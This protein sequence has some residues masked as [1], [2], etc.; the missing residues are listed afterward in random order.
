MRRQTGAPTPRRRTA[1][2]GPSASRNL[3]RSIPVGR[4]SALRLGDRAHCRSCACLVLPRLDDARH[5]RDHGL[6]GDLRQ[7]AKMAPP[8]AANLPALR[9]RPLLLTGDD[10]QRMWIRR[11]ARVATAPLPTAMALGAAGPGAG[12]DSLARLS[13]PGHRS[14]RLGRRGSDHGAHTHAAAIETDDLRG[15]IPPRLRR[16]QDPSMAQAARQ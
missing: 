15:A 11:A 3:R 14:A 8:S 5:R 16:R 10:V 6:V 13:R 2:P 4:R 9:L 7:R 12:I 1:R